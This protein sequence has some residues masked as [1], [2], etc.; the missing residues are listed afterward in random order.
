MAAT[1][2]VSVVIPAFN[3]EHYIRETLDSILAQTYS[4]IEV[5]V[6][7]DKST[8]G[9]RE[10]VLSYG[11]RVKYL[12]LPANSGGCS[13]PRNEGVKAASGEL[14]L[15]ADSD[16]LSTPTRIAEQVELFRAHPEVGLI[17][18]NYQDFDTSG[19][20]PRTHFDDCPQ[21]TDLIQRLPD[22]SAGIVL[23]PERSTELLLSEN[24]GSASPIVRREVFDKVGFFDPVLRASE[25]FEFQYRVASQYPIGL[26]PKTGWYK[27]IHRTSMSSNT[28][29]IM[30]HKILTRRR[31]LER[32]TVPRRR[33]KLER[34]IG[35]CY[36]D[37]AYYYTGRNNALA[38]KNTLILLRYRPAAVPR[39]LLRIVLDLLGR[40]TNGTRGMATS[41]IRAAQ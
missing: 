39:L 37:L 8:D 1:P 6:V 30:R 28:P 16:D 35:G 38:M 14:I 5:I 31:L 25:D 20:D 2:R 7:D 13:V 9:T 32:E 34:M 26:L 29:N 21:L 22:A 12:P 3:A 24:Y 18:S 17:F 40:D 23:S 19:I 36:F 11:D 4:N 27:R 41:I 33:R 10:C 15:F